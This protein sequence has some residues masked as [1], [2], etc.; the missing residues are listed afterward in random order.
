MKQCNRL[1]LSSGLAWAWCLGNEFAASASGEKEKESAV[2]KEPEDADLN[3]RQSNKATELAT[4]SK[5]EDLNDHSHSQSLL[6]EPAEDDQ[7]KSEQVSEPSNVDKSEK[8]DPQ[9]S[10]D[11]DKNLDQDDTEAAQGS[12]PAHD[13]EMVDRKDLEA[14]PSEIHTATEGLENADQGVYLEDASNGLGDTR[15]AQLA[16]LAEQADLR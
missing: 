5:H 16:N 6:A 1:L 8:T 7:S 3:A 2:P 15:T 4:S 14:G 11:Q 12:S 13:F 9:D 10:L